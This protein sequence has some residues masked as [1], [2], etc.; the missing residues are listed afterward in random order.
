MELAHTTI[1]HAAARYVLTIN[2]WQYS[3][4]K[5]KIPNCWNTQNPLAKNVKFENINESAVLGSDQR[6]DCKALK[7]W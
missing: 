1:K 6:S 7:N 4:K 2:N 5:V 3:I